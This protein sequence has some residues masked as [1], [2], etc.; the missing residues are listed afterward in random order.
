MTLVLSISLVSLAQDATTD[1]KFEIPATDEGLPGEGTIRRYDWFRNLW[2]NKRSKWATQ[3]D[4]D[5]GAIVFLGDSITQG[6]GD[7]LGNSF[8]DLKVANRGISGD[9]TRGMLLRLDEDV[10]SLNP[11]AVVML[12]GTNDLEEQDEPATIAANFKRI[13]A[14]LKK[15][16]PQMPIIVCEVFPS[17]ENKSRPADKIKEVNRLYKEAVHGDP[18][19]TV[20]DTWTLFADKE[21]N[22]KAAEFPDLLHPNKV[23]YDMWAAALRPI[24]A[25]LGYLETEPDNFAVEPGFVSLF[26]GKDLTGWMFKQTPEGKKFPKGLAWPTYAEDIVFDG[27]TASSDGRYLAINDR[28]A[29]T[30]PAEG[31]RIQQLW[32][33][34]EFPSDFILKLEFRATPNADSGVFL[35]VPQLQCRDYPLAGPYKEL[36]NYKPQEWNEMVVTVKDNVAHCTCNGE[37]LEEALQLPETGPI[38]LEGDR[39]QMEYRRIRVKELK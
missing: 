7:S 26:N 10:L 16:N 29:V 37:V 19:V 20:L 13:I 15:H 24:F 4:A 35:R 17:S 30:T 31:R 9:T 1:A 14:A 5:Q 32:T 39:G 36:K 6:W 34:K 12:M 11:K 25:T 28:L 33:T 23:G 8:G 2:K 18:Q 3:V 38:G 22:A 21:G 27:K